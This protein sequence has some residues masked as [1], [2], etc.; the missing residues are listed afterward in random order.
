MALRTRFT[1]LVG[2]DVPVM[3]GGMQWV[4]RAQL[5]A[6]V[7]NAGGLGTISALTHATPEGLIA[8]IARMKDLTDKPFAVNLTILPSISPPPYAE[9][10][11]AIITSGVSVV[12]TAGSNPGEHLAHFHDAGLKVVHKC[13]SVRHAV[14]AQDLGVDAVSIDGF[15]AAGHPGEDDIPNLILIAATAARLEIPF[16]GCGGF[17][18]GRGLVAA[19]ALGADGVS[20]GTR[21]MCTAESPVH[22]AVKERIVANDERDTQLIFRPLKNTARVANNTV[23]REVVG[24]LAA[25]GAFEDVRTLVAGA[26]GRTVFE[27]GDIEA[28]IWHASTAQGLIHDIPSAAELLARIVDEAEQVITTRLADIVRA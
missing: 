7:S 19:L 26:R 8:E 23:S 21:L 22:Q 10:R 6:A 4:G 15:E 16:V 9:Y 20:M 1:E 28:G 24:I 11:D 2:I 13:T 17:V 3:Q 5:A 18:D 27:T 12:E 14:K 25:G